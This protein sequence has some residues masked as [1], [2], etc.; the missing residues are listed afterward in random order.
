MLLNMIK[1]L[2]LSENDD[3][4]FHTRSEIS[5]VC[6]HF[7]K[8]IS[9]P[10]HNV[11]MQLLENDSD[12]AGPEACHGLLG[13]TDMIFEMLSTS[14]T[15]A[16]RQCVVIFEAFAPICAD[17]TRKKRAA[18]RK[19]SRSASVDEGR[20]GGVSVRS[21]ILQKTG[22]PE[23]L[24]MDYVRQ[25]FEGS[26]IFVAGE[27]RNCLIPPHPADRS[28]LPP[29][30]AWLRRMARAL[31]LYYWALNGRFVLSAEVFDS[32]A[33]LF[34]SRVF[35][36]ARVFIEE[37]ALKPD[38][39]EE[40]IL[41]R[42]KVLGVR[43]TKCTVATRLVRL[44]HLL[45]E[46]FPKFEQTWTLITDKFL[47]LVYKSILSPES[48]GYDVTD[49]VKISQLQEQFAG[50]VVKLFSRR[51]DKKKSMS[52][53]LCRL[54]S[55]DSSISSD[56]WSLAAFR[57]RSSRSVVLL[58]GLLKLWNARVLRDAL[59]DRIPEIKLK[60]FNEAFSVCE[61]DPSP[62]DINIATQM[63]R[64]S[65]RMDISPDEIFQAIA[66]TTPVS[67]AIKPDNELENERDRE[68]K[69]DLFY[70]HFSSVLDHHFIRRFEGFSK[71]VLSKIGEL[72]A[73]GLS[74]AAGQ[75]F[76]VLT[77]ML[78]HLSRFS[79]QKIIGGSIKNG[80]EDASST[81]SRFMK[82]LLVELSKAAPF[83][84]RSEVQRRFELGLIEKFIA[85]EKSILSSDDPVNQTIVRSYLNCLERK[86]STNVKLKALTLLPTFLGGS[87]SV[88]RPILDRV[89]LMTTEP[90]FPAHSRDLN[91][92]SDD[93]KDYALLM[94]SLLH[95]ISS[96]RS[97]DMLDVLLPTFRE[98][99]HA[100]KSKIQKGI[101]ALIQQLVLPGRQ[102]ECLEFCKHS[103]ASVMN[104][105]LD[106]NPTD[107][108]RHWLCVSVL[109]PL[110]K[111]APIST[112]TRFYNE[113]QKKLFVLVKVTNIGTSGSVRSRQLELLEFECVYELLAVSFERLSKQ[114]QASTGVAHAHIIR[115][116]HSHSR[117]KA[118]ASQNG[119]AEVSET[120]FHQAAYKC[121]TRCLICT[122]KGKK[123][124]AFYN[125]LLFEENPQRMLLL[126][127]G[128]IDC[129]QKLRFTVDTDFEQSNTELMKFIREPGRSRGVQFERYVGD[130]Y[131]VESSLSQDVSMMSS[132]VGGSM[133]QAGRQGAYS[134]QAEAWRS[135]A[136]NSD[137]IEQNGDAMDVSP[138]SSDGDDPESK[139]PPALNGSEDIGDLELDPLGSMPTMKPMLDTIGVMVKTFGQS[140][141]GSL[142]PPD[143]IRHLYTKLG[144]SE[145][146]PNIRWYIA[147]VVV[148]RAP[149]FSAYAEKFFGP[150][151]ELCLA[152]DVDK[153]GFHYMLR[154]ICALFLNGWKDFRPMDYSTNRDYCSHFI[155]KL[156]S[157]AASYGS[158][159]GKRK[160]MKNNLAL[161][162]LLIE[163][164]KHLICIRKHI[165]IQLLRS[166]K[167]D[168]ECAG[169]SNIWKERRNV[170]TNLLASLVANGLPAYDERLD[171]E[172]PTNV[173]FGSIINNMNSHLKTVYSGSAHLYALILKKGNDGNTI[174]VPDFRNHF[175]DCVRRLYTQQVDKFV[176]VLNEIG[177]VYPEFFD[178]SLIAPVFQLLPRAR[179]RFEA[180][181]LEVVKW[182]VDRTNDDEE[183]LKALRHVMPSVLKNGHAPSL[184]L[185]LVILYKTINH[186]D[187][188]W[189]LEAVKQVLDA[190]LTVC[191]QHKKSSVRISLFNIL[192][193][194]FDNNRDVRS[195]EELLSSIK[196]A[197][198]R[199]LADDENLIRKKLL[200]F[201][202]QRLS[203]TEDIQSRLVYILTE[204]YHPDAEEH[205][206][207]YAVHLLLDPCRD[208]ADFDRPISDSSLNSKIAFRPCHIDGTWHERSNPMAPTTFSQESS[209]G[210]T[211]GFAAPAGMVLAT[212][213]DKW[214][215]T[216][217]LATFNNPDQNFDKNFGKL[218]T[219]S[220]NFTQGTFAE[221]NSDLFGGSLA[222]FNDQRGR[223]TVS[224]RKRKHPSSAGSSIGPSQPVVGMRFSRSKQ[225]SQRTKAMRVRDLK[226]RSHA[227]FLALQKQKTANDVRLFREY[228]EGELPDIQIPHRELLLPLQA[229][230]SDPGLAKDLFLQVFKGILKELQRMSDSDGAKYNAQI[231]AALA[232][233]LNQTRAQSAHAVTVFLLALLE[234]PEYKVEPETVGEVARKSANLQAGIL[235]LER[236]MKVEPESGSHRVK[237]RRKAL[238]ERGYSE[239]VAAQLARLYSCL[240][241]HD[242]AMSLHKKFSSLPETDEAIQATIRG[243]HSKAQEIYGDLIHKIN[244]EDHDW[245]EKEP[246]AHEID[247]WRDEYME[248]FTR[249]CQWDRLRSKVLAPVSNDP[250]RLWGYLGEYEDDVRIKDKY[251]RY[252]IEASQKQGNWRDEL[253]G[254]IDTSLANEAHSKMLEMSHYSDLAQ[255]FA[256]RTDVER[257]K[258]YLEKAYSQ[259][260]SQWTD[261][262]KFAQGARLELLQQLQQM[263]EAGEFIDS[264]QKSDPKVISSLANMW[265]T[266]F[267]SAAD[268]T[269]VWDGV[270]SNRMLFLKRLSE[271]SPVSCHQAKDIM[272]SSFIQAAKT[273]A[274]S[275]NFDVADYYIN[276]AR[277]V[278]NGEENFVHIVNFGGFELRYARYLYRGARPEK[279]F[280]LLQRFR[281]FSETSRTRNPGSEIHRKSWDLHGDIC[282]LVGNL[283]AQSENP[284]SVEGNPAIDMYRKAEKSYR[285]NTKGYL[286]GVIAGDSSL[287]APL[288]KLGEFCFSRL[289][290]MLTDQ[291]G[292]GKM[293]ESEE[294]LV[295]RQELSE[296]AM[297]TVLGAMKFD[298]TEARDRFPRVMELYTSFPDLSQKFVELTNQIPSWMFLSWTPQLLACLGTTNASNVMKILERMSLDYPQAMFYPF[299]L[300]CADLK[301]NPSAG[302]FVKALENLFADQR[303]LKD[304]VEAMGSLMNRTTRLYSALNR[305]RLVHSRMDKEKTKKEYQAIHDKFL[306]VN[307]VTNCSFHQDFVKKWKPIVEGKFGKPS[308]CSKLIAMNP[309]TLKILVEK[310]WR[311]SG[312]SEKESAGH[313][314]L[315]GM[316]RWLSDFEMHVNKDCYDNMYLEMPGQYSG[317]QRPDPDSHLRISG[318]DSDVLVMGS[319]MKPKRITVRC[320]N[321]K[322]YRLLVKGGE[323][324]RM[325][326]RF[327]QMFD[328]FNKVMSSDPSCR[329]RNMSLRRYDVVPLTR[330]IG[331]IEWLPNTKPIKMMMDEKR[332]DCF[333][334]MGKYFD[335][336]I[337]KDFPK[338]PPDKQKPSTVYYQ[339]MF[340]QMSD[341]KMC[342]YFLKFQRDFSPNI[343]SS[344]LRDLCSSVESYIALRS[345]FLT[346]FSVITI[347]TYILGLGDRH[348]D[349]YLIDESNGSMVSIDFGAA[350]GQGLNLGIPELIPIRMTRQFL[351]LMDPLDG[352]TLIK[353]DMTVVLRALQAQKQSILNV[354][355]V[356]VKEPHLDWVK[357]A[358]RKMKGRINKTQNSGSSSNN[359]SADIEWYPNQ[360]INIAKMKLSGYNSKAVMLKEFENSSH[361]A[362]PFASKLKEFIKG[363]RDSTRKSAPDKCTPE[364]QIDILMEHATDTNIQ[365]RSWVGLA[366]WL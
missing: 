223:R 203:Q 206:L 52:A 365:A 201:W 92:K 133:S 316:S 358:G 266:R 127:E 140:W 21:W 65:L 207:G 222:V 63:L 209:G 87:E 265:K 185:L 74:G 45:L 324:L 61:G 159:T 106:D 3:E 88:R 331:L 193:H 305:L 31:D 344:A 83:D 232:S 231:A 73:S 354:L 249:L 341:R 38:H 318:F 59:L 130:R 278:A 167:S 14:A 190:L 274:D 303:L 217:S 359:A 113:N 36:A 104:R 306:Q 214:S 101:L 153:I 264:V 339:R 315:S 48:A 228:R 22:G 328:V 335:D 293:A 168:P 119:D 5:R 132:V 241:A 109:V 177:T 146:H 164:W 244:D 283:M 250:N 58:N 291:D 67:K 272:V 10:K 158:S 261:L 30:A 273:V 234:C 26:D 254:F 194:L 189:N 237:R 258:Y 219:S 9:D 236:M 319:L 69:G 284:I 165:I 47:A 94:D 338:D 175:R 91:Q 192:I 93:F 197:L 326:Q 356:F 128:I 1:S 270:V 50:L 239:R 257:T 182:K 330:E 288:M 86:T 11:Y 2:Q 362:T 253:N 191:H 148:L 85:S 8:I 309:R 145:T 16:R 64:L 340:Q 13:F 108:A 248:S 33:V 260:L 215:L 70:R 129:K 280:K 243:E 25:V 262:P 329:S 102:D 20:E 162:R 56:N 72:S 186:W 345:Q 160:K 205:W 27:L 230:S 353:Q 142:D 334:F 290:S 55:S 226:K 118:T 195:D 111:C 187:K 105:E 76:M 110:L 312:L 307:E 178:R 263:T 208:S 297:E 95:T 170:G 137:E 100:L 43:S 202:K 7:T 57:R 23:G 281:A 277:R 325:D 24:G 313:K 188:A 352:E 184:N 336:V 171:K 134:F 78:E 337:N 28:R 77:N 60:L 279:V 292:D 287:S 268:P 89:A 131:L 40:Q 294:E 68:T 172:I 246:L 98:K 196:L 143:W 174:G 81:A 200:N 180:G 183:D 275:R 276:A 227:A 123:S 169:N 321:E 138:E 304:F 286:S 12:R 259:V 320:D 97:F 342:E 296:T 310:T 32:G 285:E 46:H 44:I 267:P 347:C 247:F 120:A 6:E 221:G 154:D 115:Q 42:S 346:S 18:R 37:F 125:R 323:D 255:I 84:E 141:A 82:H 360:K 252:Y 363:G 149:A 238:P 233:C 212:Q 218:A 333:A 349:N 163:R 213:T 19:R 299:Q 210:S 151:V 271:L 41:D 156:M 157:V 245:G 4:S 144:D 107:N 301:D 350:F 117:L 357:Q 269:S 126:W 112:V 351:R 322:E 173:L 71:F 240:G 355:D 343:L 332:P 311:N 135:R 302:H 314:H 152:H 79:V 179:D 122:Q 121:L 54:I 103:Y 136:R 147:R 348:L 225:Y 90:P 150:L 216:Q 17:F 53:S 51:L 49:A 34:E 114:A 251:I 235:L 176:A 155:E 327:E 29:V 96:V 198:L 308:N 256:A 66:D 220:M 295:R 204:M 364:R 229:L 181:A 242:V 116:A 361:S 62:G 166:E 211:P 15:H 99:D 300:T 282:L 39:W 80:H 75:V 289:D 139:E 161:I 366:L 199:G 317:H 35:E 224:R 298:S 124:F